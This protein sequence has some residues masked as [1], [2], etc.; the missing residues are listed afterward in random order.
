MVKGP[1]ILTGR[2]DAMH[3]F[4][5]DLSEL[6]K[7]GVD[8][9]IFRKAS[10]AA[11][12]RALN[13]TLI[14][15]RTDSVREIREMAPLKA[16]VIRKTMSIKRAKPSLQT[17]QVVSKGERLNLIHYKARQTKKGVTVQISKD[18]PRTLVPGAFIAQPHGGRQVFRRDNYSCDYG[19]RKMKRKNIPWAKLPKKYR[20]PIHRKTGPAVPDIMGRELVINKIEEKTATRLEKNSMH[21]LEFEISKLIHGR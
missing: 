11:T 13:K 2:F 15:V 10:E 16:L 21:E 17:G 12:V 18:K 6:R 9:K 7:L 5:V 20:L 8:F 19:P 1:A 4:D 3:N 14:G